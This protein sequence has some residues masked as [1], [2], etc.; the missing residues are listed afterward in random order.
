MKFNIKNFINK[1][2]DKKK[3]DD[4]KILDYIDYSSFIT[5]YIT[6]KYSDLYGITINQFKANISLLTAITSSQHKIINEAINSD[7]MVQI[8]SLLKM[9][10]LPYSV[11]V[12]GFKYTNIDIYLKINIFMILMVDTLTDLNDKIVNIISNNNDQEASYK[13]D[14][15]N[16]EFEREYIKKIE[17]GRLFV[18]NAIDYGFPDKNIKFDNKERVILVS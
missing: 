13:I 9:E 11:I 1:T 3:L 8:R 15:L 17:N 16:K 18:D 5:Y 7:K 12:S 14:D 2:N 4:F 10:N 6:R